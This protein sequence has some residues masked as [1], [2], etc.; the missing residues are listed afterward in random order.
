MKTAIIIVDHGSRNADSN[1]LLHTVAQRFF[2]LYHTRYPIVEPA[3][4]ELA[5]PSIAEAFQNC[6]ERGADRVIIAPYFLGPGKH[7]TI[8]IPN[9]LANA[10]QPYPFVDYALAGPL[11]VDELTLRLLD[12]RIEEALD[13]SSI[14]ELQRI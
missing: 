12:K 4:M 6:V 8:D 2:E 5:Q 3:H 13:G 11:G 7:W 9:L 1:A 14:G 10:A